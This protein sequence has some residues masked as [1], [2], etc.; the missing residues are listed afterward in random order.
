[1]AALVIGGM[2]PD[3]LTGLHG[4]GLRLYVRFLACFRKL[5]EW[6]AGCG[7]AFGK[8]LLSRDIQSERCDEL[9]LAVSAA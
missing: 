8:I 9:L 7:V 4:E 6:I 1:M 5:L 2:L 3:F